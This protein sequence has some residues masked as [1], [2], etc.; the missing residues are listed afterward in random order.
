MD[1]KNTLGYR[2]DYLKPYQRTGFNQY[3]Y[4]SEGVLNKVLPK[5]L[6]RGNSVLVTFLQLIDVR[7]IMILKYV[8]RLKRFKYI[9]WYE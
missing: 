2:Y 4:A 6:F 8:D 9:T 5:I 3:D 7:I 1:F